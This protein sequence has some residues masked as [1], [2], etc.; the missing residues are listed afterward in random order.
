MAVS[1]SLSSE[2]QTVQ[3]PILQYAQEIGWIYLSPDEALR[4]R[5][6]QDKLLLWE[7]FTQKVQAL[8]SRIVD[9]IKAEEIG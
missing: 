3:K 6:G 7:I 9:H 4:M 2:A 1:L 8:N 5:R